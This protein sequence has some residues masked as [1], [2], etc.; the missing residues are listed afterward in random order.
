MSTCLH[1][2]GTNQYLGKMYVY[3]LLI[4]GLSEGSNSNPDMQASHVDNL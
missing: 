3:R 4:L 1:I 2:P